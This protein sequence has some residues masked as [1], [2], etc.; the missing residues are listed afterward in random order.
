MHI[1]HVHMKIRPERIDKFIAATLA[2]ALNTLKEPGCV[3]F[4]L[5]QDTADGSHFE[6]IEI[7]RD[8]AAH[9]AHRE[10]EHY[11]A[12]A[13]RVADDFAEPRSRTFYRNIYPD[14]DAF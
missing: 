11:H 13:E 5:V 14:D 1:L 8:Q 3:R 2:N 12:W 6:L 10:S 4:D 9:A 7:Y